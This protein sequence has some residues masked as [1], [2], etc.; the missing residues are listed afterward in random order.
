MTAECISPIQ[1]TRLRLVRSNACG[2][3]VTGAGSQIVTDGFVEVNVSPQYQ[4]GTE[5]RLA[6]ANGDFCVNAD[7]D[8][9]LLRADLDMRFC[10]IN[11]DGV[12]ITTGMTLITTGAPATGTGFWAVEGAVVARFSLELWAA[13]PE[14]CTGS[15]ARYAYWAFPHVGSGRMNDFS[16]KDDVIEWRITAKTKK[17]NTLWGSGPGAVKYIN[18]VPANAHWGFNIVHIDPPAVTGPDCGAQTL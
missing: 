18:Q 11:P 5:Y 10:M 3:P 1:G 4:D 7:G 14:T 15:Q 6:K 9:R 12:V 17:A 13:D 16:V 8:D 2:V